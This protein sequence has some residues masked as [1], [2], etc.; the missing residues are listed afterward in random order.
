MTAKPRQPGRK[1]LKQSLKDIFQRRRAR[2]DR[3]ARDTVGSGILRWADPSEFQL[4]S[5][6]TFSSFPD[7]SASVFGAEEC[8]IINP[9]PDRFKTSPSKQYPDSQTRESLLPVT[10]LSHIDLHHA[11][12][13][14]S[15]V[16]HY[17]TQKVT[18]PSDTS[19]LSREASISNLSSI[20]CASTLKL[21]QSRQ[22][23]DNA[24]RGQNSSGDSLKGHVASARRQEAQVSWLQSPSV[25]YA[26]IIGDG[27]SNGTKARIHQQDDTI[28]AVGQ[29]EHFKSF[30]VLDTALPG[31]PVVA[32]SWELRYALDIGEPF[33]LNS[34]EC[35]GASM[36]V[37]TGQDAA[38]EPVTHLVLFAPLASPSSGRGRFLLASLIDVT[39]FI[40]DAASLPELDTSPGSSLSDRDL[41]TVL[42]DDPSSR[43]P[44][45]TYK[46]SAEDLLGGCLLP[47]DRDP[48]QIS[49]DD[50]WL[51]LALEEK[52]KASTTSGSKPRSTSR[53]DKKTKKTSPSFATSKVVDEVLE[54]FMNGLRELYSDFFL[55]GK[56]PL[57]DT[58]YEI[59]NVSPAVF[60]A[61]DY[62]HGHLSHTEEQ[63]IVEL[64][65]SLAKDAPFNISV[66]WG[67]QGV[68]KLLYCSPLYGQNSH[69]WIC[70][71]V[72]D[73]VPQLW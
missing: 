11:Y 45:A 67:F 16:P 58:V 41:Q 56:S 73:R 32:T 14:R 23:I 20:S 17:S 7:G 4:F 63:T 35:E 64:T 68:D 43:W 38:G 1:S 70:F 53:V 25:S 31:C 15:T 42:H 12:L 62:M 33:F 72:D 26:S 6:T 10:S 34:C 66:R 8:T 55:L 19:V 52:S 59:C 40:Q 49:P 28:S 47:E 48:Y 44:P 5:V 27:T 30:C 69:T 60:A 21:Q 13:Q 9:I 29:V 61:K 65:T 36:D 51:N 57:D 50:I 37:V 46:L 2:S 71:V 18:S 54:D 3:Y 22:R 39:R 24:E